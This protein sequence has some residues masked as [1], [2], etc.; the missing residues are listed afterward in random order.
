MDEA[1]AQQKAKAADKKEKAKATDKKAKEAKV[2][3]PQQGGEGAAAAGATAGAEVKEKQQQQQQPLGGVTVKERRALERMQEKLRKRAEPRTLFCNKCKDDVTT[4][5][6]EDSQSYDK[7]D[8]GWQWQGAKHDA[9]KCGKCNVVSVQFNRAQL[10]L[11]AFQHLSNEEASQF[12]L[13][14]RNLVGKKLAEFA[15][16]YFEKEVTT[17]EEKR[18]SGQYLPLKVWGTQG[19]DTAA[20]ERSCEDWYDDPA[21]GRCYKVTIYSEES[22]HRDQ[23]KIKQVLEAK[24]SA[25]IQKGPAKPRGNGGAGRKIMVPKLNSDPAQWEDE[26]HNAFK[27]TYAQILQVKSEALQAEDLGI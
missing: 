11:C 23:E 7:L 25:K 3:Q 10:S 22:V 27:T 24:G 14:A 5:W 18:A 16:F 20:I 4:L 1:R 2:A 21:Y 8:K 6:D 26:Q 15:A 13:G 17:I 19:W 12:F 9:V